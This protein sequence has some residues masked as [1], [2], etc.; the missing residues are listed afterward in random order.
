[1]KLTEIALKNSIRS[2]SGRSTKTGQLM[3]V[4]GTVAFYFENL[5]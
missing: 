1:M 2:H 4:M 5:T 3:L